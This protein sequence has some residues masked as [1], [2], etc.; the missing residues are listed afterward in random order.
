MDTAI[1]SSIGNSVGPKYICG[2]DE[3]F[4][5]YVIC[6][7]SPPILIKIHEEPE[8]KIV[9]DEQNPVFANGEDDEDE[10]DDNDSEIEEF[11]I[12]KFL[13]EPFWITQTGVKPMSVE[14]GTSAVKEAVK[15]AMHFYIEQQKKME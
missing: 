12:T 1:T 6:L 4:T 2:I 3:E 14:R 8:T 7:D 15:S 13:V 10:D 9:D 5:E 11:I